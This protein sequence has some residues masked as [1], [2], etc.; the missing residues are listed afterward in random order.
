MSTERATKT[1]PEGR[2]TKVTFA[3]KTSVKRDFSAKDFA[4]ALV[5][6]RPSA[7]GGMSIAEREAWVRSRE[8]AVGRN[9]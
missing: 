8:S 6:S 1:R 7:G 2:V 3:G 9:A 5:R 4:A